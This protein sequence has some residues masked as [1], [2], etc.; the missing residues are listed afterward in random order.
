MIK[1]ERMENGFMIEM[2]GTDVNLI[3][4][5]AHAASAYHVKAIKEFMKKNPNMDVKN[6][7]HASV[8]LFGLIMAGA[9]EQQLGA[10]GKEETKVDADFKAIPFDIVRKKGG[11]VQ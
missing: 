4:E 11:P 3:E 2:D 7:I 8:D 5:I 1:V 10:D 6:A 9:M